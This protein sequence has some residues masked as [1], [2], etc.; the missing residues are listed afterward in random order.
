MV[1][2]RRGDL[3]GESGLALADH[4]GQVRERIARRLGRFDP[5]LE[6]AITRQPAL[7]LA[8]RGHPEDVDPVDQAGLGQ[9][10][11]RHHH[12]WP[13]LPFGGQH[14]WQHPVHRPHP[15]VEGQLPSSTVF[16]SRYH[17]LLRLADSTAQARA[18]S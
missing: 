4:V 11:D 18:M 3:H 8:Q 17:V 2:T 15:T 10:A 1:G 6:L 14:R 13:A 16:S 9:I 5:V 7:Q 12:R